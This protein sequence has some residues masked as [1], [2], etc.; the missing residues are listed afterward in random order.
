MIKK[1]C[2]FLLIVISMA[3]FIPFAS[4]LP[5]GLEKV[6]ETFGVKEQDPIWNGLMKDYSIETINNPINS[7][8]VSGTIGILI[9]LIAGLFLGK[10]LEIKD[11][12]NVS[13]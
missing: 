13:K 3:I 10:T 12:Q 5:D 4:N 1:I 2:V 11:Y 9:V 8:F 7:T 6:V